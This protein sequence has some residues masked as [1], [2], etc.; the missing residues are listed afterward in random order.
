MTKI[1]FLPGM[2]IMALISG[3]TLI[4]CHR[5]ADSS[6]VGTWVNSDEIEVQFHNDGYWEVSTQGIPNTK[7]TYTTD[8]NTI[9]RKMTHLHGGVFDDLESKWYTESELRS[10]MAEKNIFTY[11]V[12]FPFERQTEIFTYSLSGNTITFTY[13]GTDRDETETFTQT[14]TRK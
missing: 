9:T 13:T 3:M 4:V 8:G 1:N 2:L 7:G 12:L 5:G 6:L 10:F 14:F 11:M